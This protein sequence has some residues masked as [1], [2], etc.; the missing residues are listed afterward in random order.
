V[1]AEFSKF[2]AASRIINMAAGGQPAWIVDHWI[3][4]ML[5]C[6]RYRDDIAGGLSEA[7]KPSVLL[8]GSQTSK[9]L[10]IAQTMFTFLFASQ[11]A[12]SSAPTWLFQ[13]MAQRPD[14]LD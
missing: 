10:K 7:E 5:E 12:S 6:P 14:I 1:L 2:A 8:R 9:S 4:R 11:V 3:S 13:I